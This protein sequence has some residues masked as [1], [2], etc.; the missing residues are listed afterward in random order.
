M[1]NMESTG[2]ACV[3]R[4]RRKDQSIFRLLSPRIFVL[5]PIPTLDW[6]KFVARNSTSSPPSPFSTL[7]AV[8]YALL[9]PLV[10]LD[11]PPR[12]PRL[13][14]RTMQSFMKITGTKTGNRIG[15]YGEGWRMGCCCELG[16]GYGGTGLYGSYGTGLACIAMMMNFK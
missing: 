1:R 5:P 6:P 8:S 9:P 3:V 4:P 16:D 7:S 14:M 12:V 15:M 10:N 11:L 2:G 13:R